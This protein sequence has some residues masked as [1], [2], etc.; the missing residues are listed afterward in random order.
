MA[1]LMLSVRCAACGEVFDTG[2]RI[3]RRNFARAT[4][5]SN[6]HTCPRCHTR[7]TYHKEEYLLHEEPPGRPET[8]APPRN[9][10][11]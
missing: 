2:I 8:L 3:D 11:V 9:P 6:Y 4:L 5:A 7:G 10:D 1:R